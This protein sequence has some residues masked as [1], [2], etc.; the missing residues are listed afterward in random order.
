MNNFVSHCGMGP[1]CGFNPWFGVHHIREITRSQHPQLLPRV[2][3]VFS[4]YIL[5]GVRGQV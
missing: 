4:G 3:S 2:P 1:G 5:Y